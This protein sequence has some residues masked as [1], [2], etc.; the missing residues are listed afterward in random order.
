VAFRQGEDERVRRAWEELLGTQLVGVAEAHNGHE[1]L[2]VDRDSRVFGASIAHDGFCFHGASFVEAMER[3]LSGRRTRPM[4]RPD[5]DRVM[6]YG[7]L[8][9]A[10]HPAIYRY[11]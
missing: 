6:L 1:E 10:D 11:R 4:L 2:Y 3:L 9:T 7:D 8:F 5:Q